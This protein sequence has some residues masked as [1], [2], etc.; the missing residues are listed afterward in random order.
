MKAKNTLYSNQRQNSKS[1]GWKR[2]KRGPKNVF[3]IIAFKRNLDCCR[4]QV[5]H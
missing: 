1:R 2:N 3:S 5:S 4:I